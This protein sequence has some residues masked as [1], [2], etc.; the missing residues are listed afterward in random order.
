M[1]AA[2]LDLQGAVFDALKA[3]DALVAAL[4]GAKFH[5]VTPADL[6]FP[7]VTFG[8]AS[9]YDW[10]TGTE[11]GSEHLF[12]LHVWSKH[13]GRK[14]A[15]ALMELVRAALHDKDLALVRHHLV[16]LRLE[17][18]EMRFDE[19]LAVYEGSMRFRAVIEAA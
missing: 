19:D 2:A 5:D 16:S 17:F 14:Q 4:G 13:K 18:S 11:T 10:S 8:R 6:G 9:V 12:T 15:L 7:Y 3:D 1:T